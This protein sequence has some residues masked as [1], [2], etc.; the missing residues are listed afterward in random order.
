MCRREIDYKTQKCTNK[1]IQSFYIMKKIRQVNLPESEQQIWEM[2]TVSLA[3][4]QIATGAFVLQV[5]QEFS[6]STV[7]FLCIGFTHCPV[8]RA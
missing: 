1:I 3:R 7:I 5:Y 2:D 6:T 8:P 4:V